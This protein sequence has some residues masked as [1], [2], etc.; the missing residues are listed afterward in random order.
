MIRCNLHTHTRFSDGS[1]HPEEYCKEAIR[2]GFEVL[3]FSDHAPV[4]FEN[5][6]ALKEEMMTQYVETILHLKAK[7]SNNTPGKNSLKILLGLE[8]DYIPE[9]SEPFKT[10]EKT[11]PF[12]YLIG[13]VHLVR[14][15][16]TGKL[17]FID[18]PEIAIY[19]QGLKEIFQGDIRVAVTAYFRQVQSMILRNKPTVI[20]HLDKIKMY[21]RNRYFSESDPWYVDLVDETLEMIRG[22]GCIVEINTRGVYKKRS[23]EFFPGVEILKKLKKLEIPVTL[24]SDAHKPHEL[25]LGF[26]N[27]INLLK[28]L[29]F[30]RLLYFDGTGRKEIPLS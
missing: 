14:N 30:E 27:A 23:E 24:V 25:S 22:T 12:D 11:Y 21:N 13:S 15:N 10:L 8:I 19:D 18:G 1:D 4:P 17:W 7:Y 29:G 26:E 28:T 3:G 5:S 20:G 2:Q 16:D 9:L 6:F